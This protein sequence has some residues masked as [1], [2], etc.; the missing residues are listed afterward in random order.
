MFQIRLIIQQRRIRGHQLFL[1]HHFPINALEEGMILYGLYVSLVGPKPLG[2][3]FL[4]QLPQQVFRLWGD[5]LGIFDMLVIQDSVND[6]V[7][8]LLIKWGQTGKHLEEHAPEAPPV[9]RLPIV[10]LLDDLWCY[11]LHRPTE[12]VGLGGA[13]QVVLGKAEISQHC[14]TRLINQDVFWFQTTNKY[15]FINQ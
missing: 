1:L 3:V 15:Y 6:V 8:I 2:G 9:T 10:M 13:N 7:S 4:K 14:V 11:L 5:V 12:T